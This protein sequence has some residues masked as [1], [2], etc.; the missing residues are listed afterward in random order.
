[1]AKLGQWKIRNGRISLSQVVEVIIASIKVSYQINLET[2][3]HLPHR[4]Q[5][6]D[7]I[8]M[9]AA[10]AHY[11]A[12]LGNRFEFLVESTGMG[13]IIVELTGQRSVRAAIEKCRRL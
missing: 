5:D 3:Q 11:P 12:F 8:I 2:G 7:H 13:W 1:M 6:I 10:S 4:F 9:T